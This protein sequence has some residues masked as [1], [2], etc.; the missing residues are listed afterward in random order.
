MES[1]GRKDQEAAVGGIRE[2]SPQATVGTDL[3]SWQEG[4]AVPG[5]G[6][7]GLEVP[8]RTHPAPGGGSCNSSSA[9]PWK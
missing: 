6:S 8:L 9:F 4:R 7:E 2:E 1:S 5:P 3:G